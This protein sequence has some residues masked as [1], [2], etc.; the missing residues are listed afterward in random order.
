[1]NLFRIFISL[2]FIFEGLSQMIVGSQRDEHNC[3][4]DGGYQ[5]CED[6]QS[7]IRS[8]ETSCASLENHNDCSNQCPPPMPCPMP[9][10]PNMENCRLNEYTDECGCQ[11]RCP[12]WDCKNINCNSDSDCH[13]NQFC[14]PTGNDNYPMVRGR[15]M[16]QNECVDKVGI[17]ETCGGMVPPQFQS[18]CLDE[19]ECVN[20]MGPMIADAPGQCK[21][22][23]QPGEHRDQYGECIVPV[24]VTIPSNCATWF[25]GCNTCQVVNGQAQI[26]TL[27]YCFT[28]NTPYCMNYHR[29][30]TTLQVG[31]VCYRFCEDNSQESINRRNDC[32]SGTVCK[33]IFSEHSISMISY[34]SCDDRAWT[35]L[36]VGH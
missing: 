13:R 16:Q 14:R 36:S 9:Y 23:C 3:V 31:D 15:R 29:D 17:N 27:M 2:T 12:S 35:C 26:C 19:L 7:C 32:P 8:W 33:S 18:R 25:D 24:E 34:D 22:R 6:T 5:W 28:Q 20:T 1:M 30:S 11:E 21:E 4:L 10:M